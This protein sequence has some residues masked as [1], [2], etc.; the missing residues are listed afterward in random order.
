LT[1]FAILVSHGGAA[2]FDVVF[3]LQANER[4]DTIRID[5]DGKTDIKK[6][7][8]HSRFETVPDAPIASFE[9]VL[10]QGPHSAL[11]ANANLCTSK[12]AM[13]T[14]LAGQN[15]ALVNQTTKIA[16]TGCPKTLTRAQKLALALKACH[17]KKGAKRASC[18]RLAR[19]KYA[20]VKKKGK[21]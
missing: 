11:A 14:Q 3:L 9:T 20:P 21:R 15:G 8:T 2:F 10:P 18:E 17:K 7:I 6:G 16:V 4:G 19:R 12:L 13:P 1:G 5:L